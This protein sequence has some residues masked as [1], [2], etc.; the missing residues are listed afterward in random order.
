MS[1]AYP[2]FDEET[3]RVLTMLQHDKSP[4]TA[5]GEVEEIETALYY[6][7][8]TCKVPLYRGL[9][10]Q[11]VKA[12]GDMKIGSNITFGKYMSFSENL[13]IA[14]QFA[15]S[16]YILVGKELYG[17]NYWKYLVTTTEEIKKEDK[18]EYD[19]IDGD[20]IIQA[21]KEEKEWIMPKEFGYKI[22][23]IKKGN[24]YTLI[25]CT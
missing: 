19:S 25:E 3:H 8:Q 6:Y 9:Y 7:L 13:S 22:T 5:K 1:K 21:A 23:N 4:L 24:T 15:K 18:A 14:K 17:F 2:K 11:E 16:G 10:D 20:Y 12:L